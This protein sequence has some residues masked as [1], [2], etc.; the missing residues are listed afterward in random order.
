MATRES[1]R[2]QTVL[3][4]L[5]LVST[6]IVILSSLFAG[7]GW[8]SGHLDEPL[9]RLVEGVI[10]DR[11][12]NIIGGKEGEVTVVDIVFEIGNLRN[13][14]TS[15]EANVKGMRDSTVAAAPVDIRHEI[16]NGAVVLYWTN[17]NNIHITG[18]QI[19]RRRDGP[20]ERDFSIIKGNT[21]TFETN[22]TDSNVTPG[23]KYVY[24]LKAYNPKTGFSPRSKYEHV[25]VPE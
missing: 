1:G 11:I 22:Y 3:M 18:Y 15:L 5:Q 4:Y 16:R 23:T 19:L 17:P 2:W 25:Q 24:R 12:D 20:H 14:I 6:T 21:G 8:I 10:K 7:I 13:K 9:K